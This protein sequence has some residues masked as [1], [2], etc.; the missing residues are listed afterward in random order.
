MISVT[1]LTKNSAKHLE[2]VLSALRSFD[3]VLI[4]DNGSSDESLQIAAQFK[5]VRIEKGTFDGF[6]PTHNK[7]SR[8]AKHDW[9]FSVD[10]D[11]VPTAALVEEIVSRDLDARCVYSIPRHNEFNGKWIRWC[12]WSP[13]RVIRIYNKTAT[14]FTDAMVHEG[15]QCEGM[16]VVELKEPLRHYSYDTIADFLTK[17]QSYSTLFAKQH[18]GKRSSSPLKAVGHAFYTFWKCYLFKR[19]FMGGYEGFLISAYNAHT[20]FYKYLKLYEA[21]QRLKKIK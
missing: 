17:M 18:A 1:V 21:N 9:I 12:G 14:K 8:L 13:D 2:E 5:N 15:V 4:F 16:E 6:G 11:E 19:G 20:A 3:E 10:S 7:A